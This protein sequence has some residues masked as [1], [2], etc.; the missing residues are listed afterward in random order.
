MWSIGLQTL[1]G[2]PA[3]RLIWTFRSSSP[4]E[5]SLYL[6]N[7]TRQLTLSYN[8][9]PPYFPPLFPPSPSPYPQVTAGHS[10]WITAPLLSLLWHLSP[11]MANQYSQPAW[12]AHSLSFWQLDFCHVSDYALRLCFHGHLPGKHCWLGH[13][14][15]QEWLPC[16]CVMH[17]VV[18]LLVWGITRKHIDKGFRGRHFFPSQL[19]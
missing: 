11:C 6:F 1:Q 3:W 7:Q 14:L 13:F 10:C 18:L 17:V 15:L 16:F 5:I 8:M 19:F 12:Q 9:D 4:G 2:T